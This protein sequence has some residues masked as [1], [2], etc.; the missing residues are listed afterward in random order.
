MNQALLMVL[1]IGTISCLLAIALSLLV[2]YGHRHPH[3][4]L[5]CALVGWLLVELLAVLLLMVAFSM[6][7]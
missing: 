7:L 1:V 6:T 4:V 5:V 3:L 2:R